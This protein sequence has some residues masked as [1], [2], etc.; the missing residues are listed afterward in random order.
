[1]YPRVLSAALAA[2]V[3]AAAFGV[4]PVAAADAH[5]RLISVDVPA[6]SPAGQLIP[7]KLVLSPEV[8][9]VDG[10]LSIDPA[11]GEVV[12]VAPG[13]DGTGL[14][15]VAMG[16]AT[17]FGAFDLGGSAK[18]T[19]VSIL[20]NPAGPGVIPVRI[21]I[22]AAADRDGRR[23]K[24]VGGQAGLSCSACRAVGSCRTR[25]PWPRCPIPA[26]AAGSASRSPT[27]SST[28][29]TSTPF[30]RAG[31]RRVAADR[32][33]A[34][35]ILLRT[36]TVMAASTSST[37]RRSRPSSRMHGSRVVPL[38]SSPMS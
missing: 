14:R 36:S 29:V 35:P 18:A 27:A 22:D 32:S 8:S 9:A 34:Q 5:V 7:I 19:T 37:C 13:L 38:P 28:T 1:M 4:V 2:F 10:R 31:T 30:E 11:A 33:A 12:G 16:N 21:S 26:R 6:S 17:A 15:P 24:V 23:L 25:P 20:I 3:A